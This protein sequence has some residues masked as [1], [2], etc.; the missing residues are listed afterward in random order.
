MICIIQQNQALRTRKTLLMLKKIV[1]LSVISFSVCAFAQNISL[2]ADFSPI[3]TI[4]P[5]NQEQ[6]KGAINIDLDNTTDASTQIDLTP[7]DS[8]YRFANATDK[9]VQCNIRASWS[10]FKTLINNTGSNDFFYLAM[11][12]KMSDLGLFDLAT[13]ATSKIKDKDITALSIEDMKRYYFPKKKL[14]PED[15]MFLAEVYSNIM[16]NDQSSESTNELLKNKNLL[17][18]SDYANYLVALGSYKSNFY[19]RANQYIDLAILQ[20]PTNLNY[21]KLKAEIVADNNKP[22]EAVKIVS[23]LKKQNLYSFE[24]EKKVNSLEQYILYKT[25]NENWEKNYHLGYYYFIENDN[26][27]SIKSLQTA[28]AA[29]KKKSNQ[30]KIL[31]LMSQV[32]LKMN[33]FEKASDAAK[34]AYKIN[35][36]CSMALLTLGDLNYRSKNFKQALKYYRQSATQDKLSYMP[37]IKE[38]QTYQQLNNTK[39]A[40]EIYQKILK[41]RFDSWEAYYNIALLDKDKETIYIKKALAVNPL[42]N[43]G[44]IQLAKTE[45]DKANYLNAAKYLSNAYYIDENDFRYYYYQGLICKNTGEFAQAEYNFKKCLKLNPKCTEARDELTPATDI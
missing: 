19:S 4:N 6:Y 12:N 14:K 5:N 31:G 7:N 33:E 20:N 9:F 15:E 39:K 32:Y 8:F 40:K 36:N 30:G 24:Y 26:S 28:F 37:L 1:F 13:L 35:N 34:K 43:D 41:T 18:N 45:I 17:S 44:W 10:D 11:A 25:K 23:D 29:T 16:Y 38:A 42:F 2:C 27:K 21:K 3:K 22:A